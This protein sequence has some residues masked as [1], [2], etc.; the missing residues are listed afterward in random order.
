M[1]FDPRI[2]LTV[3]TH[4][5]MAG[6][7]IW[8]IGSADLPL[9]VRIVAAATAAA[10]VL[11]W[12]Q[13]FTSRRFERLPWLALLLVLI[14]GLGIVEVLATGAQWPANILLGTAMLEFALL[15]S[16]SRGHPPQATNE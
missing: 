10:I 7:L 11:P 1:R 9:S 12:L 13:M 6:S 3:V 16:L 4:L 8:M 15:I 5:V 14:I 2:A